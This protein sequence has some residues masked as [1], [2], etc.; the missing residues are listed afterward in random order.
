[1]RY[2]AGLPASGMLQLHLLA[3]LPYILPSHPDHARK[4]MLRALERDRIEV[5]CGIP[6]APGFKRRYPLKARTPGNV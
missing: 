5:R 6:V 4:R 1:M 3:A 2:D